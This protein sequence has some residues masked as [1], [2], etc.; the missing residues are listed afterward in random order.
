MI[1]VVK[2]CY[3]KDFEKSRLKDLLF[4]YKTFFESRLDVHREK[5]FKGKKLKMKS[6]KMPEIFMPEIKYNTKKLLRT[7]LIMCGCYKCVSLFADIVNSSRK[8]P[9]A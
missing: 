1:F 4:K 2:P 8:I 9:V 5:K 7:F 6:F 3:Y